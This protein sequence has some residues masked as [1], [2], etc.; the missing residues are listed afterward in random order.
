VNRNWFDEADRTAHALADTLGEDGACG[1][2]LFDTAVVCGSGLATVA[3]S[4]GAA[5]SV[6]MADV[7]LPVPNVPGHGGVA[8]DVRA[9]G[10]RCL[11]LAG[12]VHLYEGWDVGDVVASVRAAHAAGCGNILLTNAAGS[13]HRNWKPGTCVL[14]KDHLNLTGANPLFGG[15][16]T[17]GGV[18]RFVD[19]SEVYSARLRDTIQDAVPR[20]LR[21]GVYAAMAGPSYETPAE[22]GMLRTLGA[23]LAGMSTACEAIAAQ[24]LGLD[25]VGLS[26]VTNLAA[27]LAGELDHQ[28]VTDI[29]AGN[30]ARL[31]SLVKHICELLVGDQA[32]GRASGQHTTVQPTA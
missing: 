2:G 15:D 18:S 32:G 22:I 27:G 19:C 25:V 7:G 31:V 3:D 30:Q 17:P 16:P 11:V 14:I 12:R 5:G 13:L 24:H 6:A 23:D 20:Q 28:E 4:L 10:G 26:L 21:E 9:G 29:A 1:D 8:L